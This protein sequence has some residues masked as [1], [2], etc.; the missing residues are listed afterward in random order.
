MTQK[1]DDHELSQLR[2][3][4]KTADRLHN[5][6]DQQSTIY[7]ALKNE[8]VDGLEQIEQLQNDSYAKLDEQFDEKL[9]EPE[10]KQIEPEAIINSKTQAGYSAEWELKYLKNIPEKLTQAVRDHDWSHYPI[11]VVQGPTKEIYEAL[12]KLNKV[13]SN[14]D[15]HD[16]LNAKYCKFF[17]GTVIPKY[18][19]KDKNL[20]FIYSMAYEYCEW[21]DSDII[22]LIFFN[23]KLKKFVHIFMKKSKVNN[24]LWYKVYVGASQ[25]G[26]K[27]GIVSRVAS[28]KNNAISRSYAW[29]SYVYIPNVNGESIKIQAFRPSPL[30]VYLFGIGAFVMIHEEHSCNWNT[31]EM[32]KAERKWQDI[33]KVL[34]GY[35]YGGYV[36]TGLNIDKFGGVDKEKNRKK[37][38]SINHKINQYVKISNKCEEIYESL[39]SDGKYCNCKICPTLGK[40]FVII[41]EEVSVL[42]AK[43]YGPETISTF[44]GVLQKLTDLH[45]ATKD[46]KHYQAYPN[47]YKYKNSWY[48][49]YQLLPKVTRK[50]VLTW[51]DAKIAL[52]DP[53]QRKKMGITDVC[54]SGWKIKE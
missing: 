8:L 7:N 40:R 53:A 16:I 35:K 15:A 11:L 30:C 48:T 38:Q 54:F 29:F 3:L 26:I 19:N 47:R 27:D 22:E 21:K 45:W 25:V 33:H 28:R 50:F 36:S 20:K 24:S 6:Y 52:L 44:N 1:K 51:K 2:D 4:L 12:N 32:N 23:A 14:F 17:T 37:E 31:N 39:K 10:A 43:G 9:D 49:K 5:E 13:T 46:G 34:N 18:N 42:V 41:W